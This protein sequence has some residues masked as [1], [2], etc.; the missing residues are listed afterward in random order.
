MYRK[1]HLMISDLTGKNSLFP[2]PESLFRR[3]NS[4]FCGRVS[5]QNRTKRADLM[6]F[7]VLFPVSRE[8]ERGDRFECDCVR[9]HAV[10]QISGARDFPRK[11]RKSGVQVAQKCLGRVSGELD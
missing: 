11:A 7:P 2:E 6:K 3:N 9:H 1:P 5:F 4:L 10:P 8:F